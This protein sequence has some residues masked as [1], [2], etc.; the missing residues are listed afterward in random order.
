MGLNIEK[1]NGLVWGIPTLLLI[2]VVGLF[3]SFRTGFAQ[4]TLFPRAVYTF[5]FQ[6]SGKEK[7]QNGTTAY[8]AL[9]TALA[10]T[11]GTG[12]LA[13]VAGAI[14]IGGPGSIFWMWMLTSLVDGGERV[15]MAIVRFIVMEDIHKCININVEY[16]MANGTLKEM[17]LS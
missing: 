8:R 1:M 4:L 10:A 13:G 6:L 17:K 5:F 15:T 11:V 12:N 14:A 7:T 16:F 3:L 9:C 2:L